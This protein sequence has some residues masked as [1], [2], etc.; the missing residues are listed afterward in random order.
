ME[1]NLGSGLLIFYYY[2]IHQNNR[3]VSDLIKVKDSNKLRWK[4]DVNTV[5]TE[6]T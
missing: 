1:H 3:T 2:S 5:L 6:D 4:L